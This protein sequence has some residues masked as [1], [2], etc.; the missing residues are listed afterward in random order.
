[1]NL[2]ILPFRT[3]DMITKG[4]SSEKKRIEEYEKILKEAG[5]LVK[6]HSTEMLFQGQGAPDWFFLDILTAKCN[7]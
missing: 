6:K 7:F 1:M 4:F 3:K 5:Y 2:G